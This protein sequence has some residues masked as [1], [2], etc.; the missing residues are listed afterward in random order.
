MDGILYIRYD[1]KGVQWGGEKRALKAYISFKNIDQ[2]TVSGACD[3]FLPILFQLKNSPSDNLA[4][5][6]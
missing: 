2:L 3:V 4:P 5:V 1:S 6:I